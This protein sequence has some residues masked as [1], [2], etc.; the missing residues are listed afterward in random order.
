MV[1]LSHPSDLGGTVQELIEHSISTVIRGGVQAEAEKLVG[2]LYDAVSDLKEARIDL[3][4]FCFDFDHVYHGQ[5]HDPDTGFIIRGGEAVDGESRTYD[6][7]ISFNYHPFI[8][9]FI[10]GGLQWRLPARFS[11]FLYKCRDWFVESENLGLAIV[12]ELDK[13]FPGYDFAKSVREA[14]KHQTPYAHSG[15]RIVTYPNG[16]ERGAASDHTDKSFLSIHLG[17]Q[18]GNLAVEGKILP[19]AS[20]DRAYVFFGE[21]A[22]KMTDK[23]LRALRHGSV[24]NG[25][26]RWAVVFFLHTNQSLQSA[27]HW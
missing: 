25:A 26:E 7:K 9:E 15:F 2:E 18:N 17:E 24:S 5:D 8:W 1:N 27:R 23:R 10:T 22:E 4:E 21:K 13:Q 20:T 16:G 19:H 11:S 14:A 6:T 12:C 3:R